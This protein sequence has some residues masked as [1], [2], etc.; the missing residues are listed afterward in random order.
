MGAD[1]SEDSQEIRKA[2]WKNEGRKNEGRKKR[3][4]E[5]AMWAAFAAIMIVL[6]VAVTSMLE[7]GLRALSAFPPTT[8]QTYEADPATLYA[9]VPNSIGWE[10]SPVREFSPV[11]LIYNNAGFRGEAALSPKKAADEIRIFA[12]GDSIVE[13]RQVAEDLTLSKKLEQLLRKDGLRASVINAGV[14][15]Y[16]TTTMNLMLRNRV[17]KFDPDMVVA[18]VFA[19]D[20]ADNFVYGNYSAHPELL[21]GEVPPDLIPKG[22]GLAKPATP[23]D[24]LMQ[25]SALYGVVA[26]LKPVNMVSEPDTSRS[27]PLDFL[28]TARA[29]N[30]ADLSEQEQ[31]IVA[32]THDGIAAMAEFCREKNIAFLVAIVP[33]PP[34]VSKDEWNIGKSQW[35]GYAREETDTSELYQRRLLDFGRRHDI[36]MID[37]LPAFRAEA[38]ASPSDHLFLTYDGH[39]SAHGH[40][41]IAR[42]IFP[43]VRSMQRRAN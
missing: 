34:Q 33:W 31:H 42:T 23:S 16:T 43:S 26:S 13:G 27:S 5:A 39:L 2:H 17:A 1:E 12:L 4:P 40:E 36:A 20:Y 41:L 19:N 25:N 35:Y 8:S 21:T 22:L 32:F 38:E 6:L 11:K 15:A 29:I 14:S 30:K 37:L 9:H 3:Y 10:I 24:W 7:V 28:H 18:F